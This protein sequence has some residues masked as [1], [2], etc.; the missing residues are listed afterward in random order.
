ALRILIIREQVHE[1]VAEHREA[2]RFEDDDRRARLEVR[3]Q[4]VEDVAQEA[5]G[6]Q[7]KTVIV[8]RTTA[9]EPPRRQHDVA[10]GGF[11]HL[12]RR[13]CGIG[14]EVIVERVRAEQDA[15]S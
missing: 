10:A 15:L 6:R 3:P 8:E 7:K 2:A 5:L 9:A 13:Y 11:E 4:L 14:M 12:D 1:L